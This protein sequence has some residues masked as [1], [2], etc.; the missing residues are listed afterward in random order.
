MEFEYKILKTEDGYIETCDSCGSDAYLCEYE[1]YNM[2]LE[3]PKVLL[4]EICS[5]TLLAS[6]I[7]RGYESVSPR[8][9][10]QVMNLFW[11]KMREWQSGNAASLKACR[12]KW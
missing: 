11:N 9:F 3:K 2:T 7:D 6:E 12:S 4:C 10:A 1:N 5:S 8:V